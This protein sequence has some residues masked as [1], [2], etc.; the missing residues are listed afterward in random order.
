V[1]VFGEIIY[2]NIIVYL[3]FGI[4][5]FDF[6]LDIFKDLSLMYNTTLIAMKIGIAITMIVTYY[7]FA[8]RKEI[9]IEL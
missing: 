3:E 5:L 4:F 6:S 1:I 7:I 9:R 8:K 2:F